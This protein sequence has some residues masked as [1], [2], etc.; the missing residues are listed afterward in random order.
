MKTHAIE[1]WYTKLAICL[2]P[3]ALVPL[4]FFALAEGWV[5]LGGGEKD[6][7]VAFPLAS[8]AIIYAITF[9][10]MWMRKKSTRVCAVRGAVGGTIPL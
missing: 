5:S 8:W 3:L 4:I 2:L 9:V 1:R 10:V 6:I 7:I